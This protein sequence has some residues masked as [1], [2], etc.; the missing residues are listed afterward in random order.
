MADRPTPA[1]ASPPKTCGHYLDWPVPAGQEGVLCGAPA[2]GWDYDWHDYT[3]A[4]HD[5]GY[6]LPLS[7][8]DHG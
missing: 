1:P 7:E 3:C 6:T 4:A 5:Q 8:D 2:I